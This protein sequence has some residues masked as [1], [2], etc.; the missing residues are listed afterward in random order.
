MFEG[1]G[2]IQFKV[3]GAA[4]HGGGLAN[5]INKFLEFISSFSGL[6]ASQ[7][8]SKIMPGIDSLVNLHPMVVHFP[9]ALLGFFVLVD[10]ASVIFKKTSWQTYASFCLNM[11]VL[12]AVFTVFLGY[13]AAYSVTH[14]E[15]SHQIMENHE[16]LALAVLAL[17]SI[18]LLWRAIFS[19]F[20]AQKP[21]SIASLIMSACLGILLI[22]TADLGA[23]MVYGHGVAVRDAGQEMAGTLTQDHDGAETEH[24]EHEA[25]HS[26][27]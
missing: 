7:I 18:L 14:D 17:S 10:W 1:R 13:K 20:L 16:H 15:L 22:L 8:F 24:H 9:I 27:H 2:Y 11:G 21:S 23:F 4:G 19:R 25:G 5:E 26:M 12:S 3:H 6:D